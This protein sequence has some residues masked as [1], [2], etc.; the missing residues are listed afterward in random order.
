MARVAGSG[1]RYVVT[2]APDEASAELAKKH[3]LL[4][5][6][7]ADYANVG[8]LVPALATGLDKSGNPWEAR[9][10]MTEDSGGATSRELIRLLVE[11]ASKGG[12]L[13]LSLPP[14]AGDGARGAGGDGA[15]AAGQR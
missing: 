15:V 10:A 6:D 9:F 2:A 7:R 5:L 12:N 1:A 14:K 8:Q 3:G 11:V 4:M 13:L